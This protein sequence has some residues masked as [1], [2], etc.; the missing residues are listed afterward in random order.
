M[1]PRDFQRLRE[2]THKVKRIETSLESTKYL[3]D[4]ALA[5][6]RDQALLHIARAH[7][8]LDEMVWIAERELLNSRAA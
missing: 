7:A 2:M 1:Q 8:F 6:S 3:Q 5:V 4:P